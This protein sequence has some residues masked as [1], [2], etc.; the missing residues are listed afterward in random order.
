MVLYF[1]HEKAGGTDEDA[2]DIGGSPVAVQG[3][4][5]IGGVI[6]TQSRR[7]KMDPEHLLAPDSA[8]ISRIDGTTRGCNEKGDHDGHRP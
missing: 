2:V 5:V 4:V 8:P 3:E 1:E 6:V 7:E